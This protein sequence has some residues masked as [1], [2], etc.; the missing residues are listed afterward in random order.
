MSEGSQDSPVQIVHRHVEAMDRRDIDAFM[1]ECD[2]GI[3]LINATGHRLLE[4]HEAV[5]LMYT[6]V[7]DANPALKTE[8][9]D[10]ISIG[11]WVFDEHLMSGFADGS[12]LHL[13][14]VYRVE[15]GR[16]QSIQL[17]Q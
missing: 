2:A 6:G 7:F 3:T 12:Q 17:F 15:G 1:A 9:M 8:L 13:V 10:R 4:G 11:S 14:R 5:R 16:I